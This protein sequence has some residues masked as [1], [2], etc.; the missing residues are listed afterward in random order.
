MVYRMKRTRDASMSALLCLF[1]LVNLASPAPIQTGNTPLGWT[2]RLSF[3]CI[4]HTGL[5]VGRLRD[6]QSLELWG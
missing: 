2:Y 6:L 3:L 1:A 4:D 5:G